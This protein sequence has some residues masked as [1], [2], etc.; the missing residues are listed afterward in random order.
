MTKEEKHHKQEVAPSVKKHKKKHAEPKVISEENYLEEK[1]IEEGLHAIYGDHKVDF[2]K[3]ER[4]RSWITNLLL[5]LVVILALLSAIGWGG[6]YVYTTYFNT[7]ATGHFS[8]AIEAPTEIVSGSETSLLIRYKNPSNVPL[9]QLALDIRLPSTF[10]VTNFSPLPSNAEERI[11]NIGSLA[12]GSEAT[13]RIDGVWLAS[14]PS[15]AP[16]QVFATYRPANFNADF[17]DIQTAYITTLQ[18]VLE[19][20]ILANE[21]GRS[22]ESL[23]YTI[24][25]TNTSSI[26]QQNV[27]VAL[28]LPEGFFLDKSLPALEAGESPLW[29]IPEI[30]PKESA[31]VTFTGSFASNTSGFRYFDVST[32]F[33][34]DDRKLLQTQTTAFTDV[35]QTGL[36][37]QLVANGSANDTTLNA[38]DQLR[39]SI[40]IENTGET[41]MKDIE[42]ALQFQGEKTIP[43]R[44]ADAD[45]A[46]GTRAINTI[47]WKP[48][49]ATPLPPKEKHTIHLVLPIQG[50]ISPSLADSFEII[51]SSSGQQALIRS[52]P[53]TI[54]L[55]SEAKFS[56]EMRYYSENGAPLGN[57]PLPPT[58]SETTTYIAFWRIENRLHDLE[59]VE[60]KA[61][62][63]PNVQFD[64]QIGSDL[65]D[66][67]FDA[68]TRTVTWTIPYLPKDLTRLEARFA[69]KITPTS[70]QVGKFVKLL[71]G[72]SFRATD[73][74]TKA[75]L[76]RATDTL[77]SEL[78]NDQDAQGLGFV[79]AE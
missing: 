76:Q 61:V 17:Q 7:S 55:N 37:L 29:I 24:T 44:W 18:S 48:I 20:T 34:N 68:S 11:W 43:I 33:A 36:S 2:T 32:S 56:A 46:G 67:R 5:S 69:V 19:T 42:L 35:I 28:T 4:S 21:E 38:D 54:S 62:L 16:V 49:L 59:N 74:T 47:T 78:P 6:F 57:G 72:T 52:T 71:S 51:A 31:M 39:L 1:L 10:E 73:S 64:N 9:A 23:D 70:D 66:I 75:I 41:E 22:G 27:E 15:S 8:L 58:V 13:I 79:I 60:V 14:I 77:D 53:L 30:A 25:V 26:P 50:E 40:A 12:A 65:G 63:P 3:L 45:L